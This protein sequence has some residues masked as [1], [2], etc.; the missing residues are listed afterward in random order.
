M[1]SLRLFKKVTDYNSLFDKAVINELDAFDEKRFSF[2]GGFDFY[3]EI[4]NVMKEMKIRIDLNSLVKD[5]D[6]LSMTKLLLLGEKL[7]NNKNFYLDNVDINL[8][9]QAKRWL[10][11]YIENDDGIYIIKSKDADFIRRIVNRVM[12]ENFDVYDFSYDVYRSYITSLQEQIRKENKEINQKRKN[13]ALQIQNLLVWKA[14]GEEFSLKDNDKSKAF[15]ANEGLSKVTKRI[16]KLNNELKEMNEIPEIYYSD[17]KETG[18]PIILDD[19]KIS[20]IKING[21]ISYGETLS[22]NGVDKDSDLFLKVLTG[23][24]VPISGE[25]Y[26]FTGED[27]I[28]DDLINNLDL[29][30]TVFEKLNLT[31]CNFDDVNILFNKYDIPINFVYKVYGDLN[32]NQKI[33]ANILKLG[34][35]NKGNLIIKNSKYLGMEETFLLKEMIDMFSGTTILDSCIINGDKVLDLS[36]GLF[37]LPNKVKRLTK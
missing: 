35:I 33:L 7:C 29:D 31:N 25:V 1:Y 15:K 37:S 14:K 23:K 4:L 19:L 8:N 28:T 17:L 26:N 36:N 32:I 11:G 10:I 9:E 21:Q 6:N 3:G 13:I 20:N 24:M 16:A 30:M 2:L 12:N 34:F 27:F 18:L 5:L 22:L